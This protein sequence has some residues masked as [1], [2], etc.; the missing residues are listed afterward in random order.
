MSF[1]FHSMP[2]FID[3][4]LEY[5]RL[6]SRPFGPLQINILIANS[7]IHR[8]QLDGVPYFQGRRVKIRIN[9]NSR[10]PPFVVLILD[11]STEPIPSYDVQHPEI[12]AWV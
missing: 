5:V 10:T 6:R 11:F 9:Q 12:G 1:T 3:R 8:T 2:M 4:T 7:S